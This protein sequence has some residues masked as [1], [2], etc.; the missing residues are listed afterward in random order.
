MKARSMELS[1]GSSPAAAGRLSG[2]AQSVGYLLSAAG[3][4]GAGLIF[5][6][7]GSWDYPLLEVIAVT[8]VQ[9]VLSLYAGRDRFTAPVG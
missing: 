7:T 5:A 2:M 9:L 8:A 1:A 4:F 3:P 6:A